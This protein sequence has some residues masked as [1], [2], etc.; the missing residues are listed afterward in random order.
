MIIDT[1][2]FKRWKQMCVRWQIENWRSSHTP[3]EHI[4]VCQPRADPE[5]QFEVDMFLV[6]SPHDSQDKQPGHTVTSGKNEKVQPAG[7][8]SG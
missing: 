4:L 1:G 7:W 8:L 6:S 3:R 2:D 5:G